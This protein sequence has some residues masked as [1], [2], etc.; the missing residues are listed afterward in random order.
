MRER[1]EEWLEFADVDLRA[2]GKLGDDEYLS[3]ATA[4]HAH[5]CAEKSIKAILELRG[6]RVPK[7]HTT[8]GFSR[9]RSEHWGSIRK[10]TKTCWMK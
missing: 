3:R 6:E 10:W 9:N 8:L 5:Q 2:A 7:I 4:F 1:A